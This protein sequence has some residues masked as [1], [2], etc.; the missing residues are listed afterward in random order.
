MVR[1]EAYFDHI[2]NSFK[3]ALNKEGGVLPSVSQIAIETPGPFPVLVSTL[4]SLRTRDEVTLKASRRLLAVADTPE[5]LI[6]IPDE[7]LEEIIYPSAFYKRK[8]ANLKTISGILMEQY[9]GEVPSNME[10]LLS[11]PGVGIK[12][13]SLTLNLGFQMEALCV[14]CHV[15]QIANRLGWVKTRTAEES[16]K[17]LKKILPSRFWIP[18]NELLVSYGQT[19]CTPLSPK[20]SLCTEREACPQIGVERSR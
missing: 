1:D 20:C 14:D 18:L 5:K 7:K 2:F 19:I 15:H 12:T 11:L 3:A 8:A 4:L 16:E 10:A 13:A 6:S 9:K 17:E